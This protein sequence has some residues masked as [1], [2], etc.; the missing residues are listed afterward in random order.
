[1]ATTLPLGHYVENRT[2]YPTS[3]KNDGETLILTFPIL[4]FHGDIATCHSHHITLNLVLKDARGTRF[5]IERKELH[6][7]ASV[8]EGHKFHSIYPSQTKETSDE[9]LHF[10]GES[11]ILTIGQTTAA[12]LKD[13][14]YIILPES[15]IVV[16]LEYGPAAVASSCTVC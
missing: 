1:M 13:N 5:S 7:V 9:V 3:F 6:K 4:G 8:S 12:Y 10:E 11:F 15:S 16:N 2:F 14:G